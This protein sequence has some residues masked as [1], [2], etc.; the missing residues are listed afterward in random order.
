[1]AQGNFAS[2]QEAADQFWAED[3]EIWNRYET[4]K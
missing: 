2:A 1:M 4:A 3:Q